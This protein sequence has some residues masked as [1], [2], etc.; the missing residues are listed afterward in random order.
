[1]A[2]SGSGKQENESQENESKEACGLTRKA[3]EDDALNYEH[4]RQKGHVI[5][6][7][8]GE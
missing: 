2:R 6:G 8:H 3:V 5:S 1:M 4:S 7:K